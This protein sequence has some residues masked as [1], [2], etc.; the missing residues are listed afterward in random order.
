MYLK[1]EIYFRLQQGFNL[2]IFS[3]KERDAAEKNP[4]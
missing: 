3:E 1:Y 4:S 2:K